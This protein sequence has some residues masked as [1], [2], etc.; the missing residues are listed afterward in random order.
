MSIYKT[1]TTETT[2]T[3]LDASDFGLS[4][5]IHTR[6]STNT[7]T[8]SKLAIANASSSDATVSVFLDHLTS[9]ADKDHYYITGT[10]TIPANV[11][12]VLD[13]TFS[14][15]LK[16]HKLVLTNTGTNPKITVRI[17]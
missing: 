3:I 17:D 15:N 5:P 4:S 9:N 6:S 7:T 13:D 8:V 11:S 12:L 14:V 1:I 10:V 2:T 16:T